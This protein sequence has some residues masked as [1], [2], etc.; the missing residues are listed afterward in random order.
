M[1]TDAK[2]VVHL[3]VR[4]VLAASQEPFGL[5][6]QT[7]AGI[8]DG[9]TLE[10]VAPFEPVPLFHVMAGRGFVS[11][12]SERDDG[13]WVM[14]FTRA[15]IAPEATV[16]AVH[17][18][19]PATAPV[20][21]KYGMDLCCGGHLSL[22]H[23]ADARRVPLET[24]SSTSCGRPSPAPTARRPGRGV[25]RY[26]FRRSAAPAFTTLTPPCETSTPQTTAN[27]HR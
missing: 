5:I 6:M 26:H 19:H 23:V 9:G 13:S 15:A 3:D 20:F 8:P 18:R 21:A 1:P 7:A 11:R 2:E 27:R 22:A 24:R 17:E 4:P 16:A 10:L 12:T 25:V 14:R